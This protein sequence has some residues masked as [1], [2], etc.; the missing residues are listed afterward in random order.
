MKNILLHREHLVSA[1][2][3]LA[4]SQQ[5]SEVWGIDL[6]V[7]GRDE[8]CS[9]TQ[10]VQLALH[11]LHSAK[12]LVDEVS[13]HVEAL[14]LQSEFAVD[15][16]DPL[17]E[18]G[19]RGVLDLGLNCLKVVDWYHVLELLLSH[20]VIDF[21]SEFDYACWV[22]KLFGILIG[23]IFLFSFFVFFE[24]VLKFLLNSGGMIALLDRFV[25]LG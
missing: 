20:P 15:V 7:L 18:E 10:E 2:L 13:G 14:W 23:H 6:L 3:V 21:L 9:D 12:I 19:S 1:K 5:V 17:Q 11:Y 22:V 24:T 4:D 8:Q 16:N 25:L